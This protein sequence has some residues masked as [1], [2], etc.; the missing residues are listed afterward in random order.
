MC[1]RD[2][3]TG[4]VGDVIGDAKVYAFENSDAAYSD[5]STKFDLYL[6]EIQTFTNLTLNILPLTNGSGSLVNN[7]RIPSV[8]LIPSIL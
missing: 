5:A 2:S 4:T 7:T 1:I 3:A 6:F 8:R